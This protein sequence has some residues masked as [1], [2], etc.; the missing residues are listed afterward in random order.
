MANDTTS[1]DRLWI[2]D[3]VATIIAAGKEIR[4]RKFVIVPNAA[5]DAATIQEYYN[6]SLAVAAYIKANSA[7]TDMVELDFGEY[8]RNFSG[9]RLSAITTPGSTKLYVYLK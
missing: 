2:L 6:G 3:T 5:G 8:G 7:D 1:N 4:V 9:F